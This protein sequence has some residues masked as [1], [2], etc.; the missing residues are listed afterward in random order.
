MK[1]ITLV[2][3]ET[4]DDFWIVSAHQTKRG[5]EKKVKE[6]KKKDEYVF[7]FLVTKRVNLEK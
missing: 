3:D 4:P 7:Q 5:A 2:I 1:H 6:L